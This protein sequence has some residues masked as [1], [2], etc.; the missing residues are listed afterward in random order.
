MTIA[1]FIDHVITPF[2]IDSAQEVRRKRESCCRH[3]PCHSDTHRET[4]GRNRF[5]GR[6]ATFSNSATKLRPSVRK[7][8]AQPLA[9]RRLPSITRGNWTH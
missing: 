4:W 9:A 3:A 7:H 1:P 5:L 6:V 8:T 2:N